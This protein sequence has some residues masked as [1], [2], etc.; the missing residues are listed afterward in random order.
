MNVRYAIQAG[1]PNQLNLHQRVSAFTHAGRVASFKIGITSDPGRRASV[2][3]A[4]G[5][6]YE[7]MVVLYSTSSKRNVREMEQILVQYFRE[8][9]RM[10]NDNAGGGGLICEDGP[11]Y[12][13]IT[14]RKP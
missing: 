13:Y 4:N 6:R 10:D 2:Y 1:W 5:T 3:T 7:E 11:Y 12:L 8:N 9:E 14:L